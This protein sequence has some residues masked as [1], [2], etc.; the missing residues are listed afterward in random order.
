MP[1]AR[2]GDASR[3][4]VRA[5]RDRLAALCR[6]TGVPVEVREYFQGQKPSIKMHFGV[7]REVEL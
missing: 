4:W 6:E 5:E 1:P 2:A 3:P 7:L